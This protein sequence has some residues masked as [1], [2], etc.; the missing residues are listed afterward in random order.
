MDL[1]TEPRSSAAMVPQ[2]QGLEQVMGLDMYLEQRIYVG[3]YVRDEKAK[4]LRRALTDLDVTDPHY[5]ECRVGY[6]RKAN[7]IH[8]WM[9]NN[10]QNGVDDCGTYYIPWAKLVELR[11]IC[12]RVQNDVSLAR[13]LLPP[14]QGFFF[15]TYEIDEW[16]LDDLQETINI[17]NKLG[18]NDDT[19]DL[20]YSSSW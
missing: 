18:D 9:V 5:I 19:T 7:A 1:P 15:G 8:G 2:Q 10:V 3:D 4:E 11:D 20:Y 13:E 14:T 16:Y 6:W 17:I 12:K